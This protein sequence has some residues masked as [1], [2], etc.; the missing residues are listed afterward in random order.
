MSRE[1]ALEIW[2]AAVDA[3]RP[4]PLVR[5]AV[6]SDP[7]IRAARRVLVV[8][9]G[10]AGPGMAAG[11][12]AAL[13]DRLD[14]V[15]GLVNVPAG[16]TAPLRR[17]RLHAGRPQ[18][19]NEPTAEGVAGA[20]EMLRLLA[21]AG[22]DDV[23]V[24]LLSGGGSA[25]LPAPVENVSLADKLAVTK[26]LHRSGATI[27]EMN[28]VRKHLSRL[29][30]G[31][32]AQAFRGARLVSLIISDVVGDP[33]DVIGS[34]PTAPDPTTF[35]DALDVL[36][37][38]GLRDATPASVL[39]HLE[40]GR[41]GLSPETPKQAPPSVENRV[42]GSNRIALDAARHRAAALGYRVLDLG[43]FVEGETREVA[44]AVAGVVRSIWRDAEPLGPPAC[45]LLGGETTVALGGAM[46]KGGRNQEFV[47]ALG[48]KL[49]SE[50]AG[51][52][53]L[54][55]GTDGEDGP[56][57]AAGAVADAATLAQVGTAEEF[58]RRHDAYHFF[59]RTGGLIKTGLTGTNV[60]D[61]RIV[62]MR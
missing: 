1:H 41:G 61:V 54:S 27:D 46:G 34:G 22:P 30:G 36:T 62:L 4:Q 48:V 40:A 43:A 51:V 21:G 28:C 10:K 33:L 18:G 14:R 8:G 35:A 12:E 60:M 57:D 19:V 6:E 32:L 39:H 5:A 53:V 3:V 59:E 42:L 23:A 13:A 58:L 55:A 29:K 26:L 37:R 56:T 9:A 50:M 45:V 38:Y 31:R 20:E 44:T 25:L 24:C 2:R 49:K 15:E 17:V 11:L 52:T 16:L 7:M 47:L